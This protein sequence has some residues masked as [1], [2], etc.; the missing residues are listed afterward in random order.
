[1]ILTKILIILTKSI[2]LT[3]QVILSEFNF[4]QW[5]N[6]DRRPRDVNFHGVLIF[7]QVIETSNKDGHE[8]ST[9]H[10][11]KKI[12]DPGLTIGVQMIKNLR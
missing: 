11:K 9:I 7:N 2:I 10:P 4:D 5:F 6:F 12:F 1:M 3:K 8:N